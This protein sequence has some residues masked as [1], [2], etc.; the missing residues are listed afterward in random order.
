MPHKD[1]VAKKEYF[2]KYYQN[3]KDKLLEKSKNYYFTD[4]GK[5]NHRIVMWKQQGV[6]SDDYNELYDK[7]INTNKCELCKCDITEG[8]GLIGKKH[9]D[10]NHETGE[11][12]NVLCGNCNVNVLRKK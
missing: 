1:P 12:R 9:L 4:E 10:H 11:F 7:Y 2:K 6:I 8:N 5:K 3:N